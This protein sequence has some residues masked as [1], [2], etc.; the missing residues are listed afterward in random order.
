MSRQR[1][2]DQGAIASQLRS[3]ALENFRASHPSHAGI[4]SDVCR[5]PSG[6]EGC[7]AGEAS[8]PGRGRSAICRPVSRRLER[9]PRAAN[10]PCQIIGNSRTG[11]RRTADEN[12]RE[13]SRR[14]GRQ[15][16]QERAPLTLPNG[17]EQT[18]RRR[19]SSGCKKKKQS[20]DDTE[21]TVLQTGGCLWK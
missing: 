19:R 21:H 5:D 4:R 14:I 6:D 12:S 13:I 11:A 1:R 7:R 2:S 8:R 17:G 15:N 20:R 9:D 3:D 18:L 10:T 16:L